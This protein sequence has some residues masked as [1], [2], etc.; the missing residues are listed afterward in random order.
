MKQNWILSILM[1]FIIYLATSSS[2]SAQE[3]QYKGEVYGNVGISGMTD[4]ETILGKGL[5]VGGGIGYRFHRRWGVTFDVSRNGHQRDTESF[6]FEGNAVVVGGS[7]QFFFRPETKVQP[8]LRFGVNYA[9][10]SGTFTRKPFNPPSGFPPVPGSSE[11]GSQN[12]I[13]PDVGFGVRIFATKKISIR[14]EARFAAHGSLRD[15]DFRRDILE[16]GLWVASFT[17]GVG[18]PWHW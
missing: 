9:R 2:V 12:F 14:P 6:K 10:Y 18:Y 8:Y 3:Y 17:I 13:G 1:L 4:D 15:Y 11:S 5:A 7:T 16:P